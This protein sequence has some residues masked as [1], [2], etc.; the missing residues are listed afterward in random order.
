MAEYN[1]S[2]SL[3]LWHPTILSAEITAALGIEPSRS[4]DVGAPRT[5]LKGTRL[6]GVYDESFWTARLLNGESV[7]RS[8]SVAIGDVP[9]N[10]AGRKD[11]SAGSSTTTA[12][13]SWIMRF[14]HAWQTSRSI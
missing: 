5:N 8:L 12:V 3:R 14:W 1:Y 6:K 4:N 11:S 9:D 10:L 7:D 2:V 13:T